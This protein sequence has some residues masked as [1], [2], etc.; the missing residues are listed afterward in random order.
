MLG[1]VPKSLEGI[2]DLNQYKEEE[3]S[4]EEINQNKD[5][6][7]FSIE[8]TDT[9]QETADNLIILIGKLLKKI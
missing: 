5:L 7:F 9:I 6:P 4:V 8:L 1:I 2:Y 3:L